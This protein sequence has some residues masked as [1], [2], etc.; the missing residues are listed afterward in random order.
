[1]LHLVSFQQ[2]GATA[3]CP[4]NKGP[5]DVHS[6]KVGDGLNLLTLNLCHADFTHGYVH[7]VSG[8]LNT[9]I[10]HEFKFRHWQ[11]HQYD[12]HCGC[13]QERNDPKAHKYQ[14]RKFNHL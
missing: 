8:E 12:H 14:Q 3:L 4:F 7:S 5:I 1:M 2:V 10:G 6:Q 11:E 9:R 13:H